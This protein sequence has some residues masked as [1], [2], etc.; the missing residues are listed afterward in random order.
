MPQAAARIFLKVTDVRCERLQD[1]SPEDAHDEG[2][3]FRPFDSSFPDYRAWLIRDYRE[4]WDSIHTKR[5]YDG[6]CVAKK[7]GHNWDAN[8][9][10]WAYV[11]E[12]TWIK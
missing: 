7:R 10:V 2:I 1:I 4:L 9:W 11:F 12:R 3:A 6:D 5:R 8:P